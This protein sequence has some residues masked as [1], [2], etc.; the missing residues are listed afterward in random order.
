MQKI[1]G[2]EGIEMAVLDCSVI[3]CAYNEDR[4]CGK[5]NIKVEGTNAKV[6]SQ[7]C[8]SS[9]KERGCGCATNRVKDIDKEVQVACEA[10]NCVFYADHKCKAT[11]IGIA[12]GDA[13]RSE[14]T[15]CASFRCNC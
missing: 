7:T 6:N 4:C 9:F 1:H 11:H 5:E 3:G 15:E 2:K 13:C 14:E 10:A 12:G 8:C